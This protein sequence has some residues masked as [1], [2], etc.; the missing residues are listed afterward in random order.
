MAHIFEIVN[1]LFAG[2]VPIADFLWDFPTNIPAYA[3]IPVLGQLSV[4]FLLLLG[5]SLYFTIK[6]GFVQVREFKSA[7]RLLKEKQNVDVGTSQLSA[8]LI[9]MGGRVGAGNIVGV[10]G[11]VTIGGPGA[12]FW[13][14]VSAFLGMAT[15]FG[16]ATLAQIYKERKDSEYVGG[17]TF[18]I[19]KIW[20][21]KAWIGIAMCV[22]YLLYNMLSIPVHTFHVFTAVSSIVDELTGRTSQVSEPFY[23]V[24]AA[25]IILVIAT[26]AFGGI[27]RATGFTDRLVPVVA[28]L[29][30]V[31]VLALILLNVGKIPG[32]ISAVIGGAFKPNALFGGSFGIAMSQGLKRGLLSNE[33]GMGTA[34]QAAAIA[35]TNHPCEQG[36]VQ[37]I[38]VFVDT[39][40]I[41]SLAGF[42]VTAGAI[43]QNPAIDWDVMKINK[44]GTFLASVKV[45]VPGETIMDTIILII[46]VVAFGLF[47]FTVLLCDLTYT[48][49]AAN[50]ISTNKKFIL[51]SRCLGALVFVPIGTLTVLSGLQLD[52]LWY[53][54]DLINVILIFINIP[55]LFVGRKIIARAYENYKQDR[56]RRFVA[57][58]IGVE[59][60]VWTKEQTEEK[61]SEN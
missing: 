38:G 49:I 27:K 12:I 6:F 33:A 47:A 14:W 4:A 18:Y 20:K 1:Q 59:S 34:T 61:N 22:M 36:F 54:S 7:L 3:Q 48:E 58:D 25:V 29:Y 50:K 43:W 41:C 53:V 23:Y 52:N 55:T 44:I 39:I 5:G 40:V 24:I 32:F 9:S 57:A 37:S 8:F 31:I 42:I 30:I 15:S 51:F 17:F 26:V 46:V 35:D 28:S 2:V 19:Q 60:N 21:N 13:M 56:T 10:T 45:L 16:E 11:A